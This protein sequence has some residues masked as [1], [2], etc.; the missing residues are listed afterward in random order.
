MTTA[1]QE[2]PI[3]RATARGS[4]DDPSLAHREGL[5]H[6][7]DRDRRAHRHQPRRARGGVHL[8]HGPLGLR[9]EHAAQRDRAARRADERHGGTWRGP[10]IASH[11]DRALAQSA[12]REGRLRLP[13]LSPDRRPQRRRQRRDPAAVSLAVGARA[14]PARVGR[15]SSASASPRAPITSRRSS[16]AAS[17]SVSPSPAPSSG[18]RASCSPTSRPAISTARWA[19]R[20]WRC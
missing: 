17:S 2:R 20:S 1:I 19:T 16:P 6:R 15:R 12:Q 4:T 5:P 13:D 8:D 7:Q 3:S 11:H 9:Q 18:G 14:A 10:P